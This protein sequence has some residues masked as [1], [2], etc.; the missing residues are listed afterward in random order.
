MTTT[1]PTNRLERQLS[2]NAAAE[3]LGVGKHYV[4]ARIKDGSITAINLAENRTV[5]RI[6]ESELARFIDSRKAA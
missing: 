1:A 6:A 3:V 5:Y 2:V 4:L